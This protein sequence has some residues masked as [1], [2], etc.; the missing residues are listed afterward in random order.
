MTNILYQAVNVPGMQNK[1]CN[2]REEAL[3]TTPAKLELIEDE[4]GLVFN[5]AFNPEIV[6][7]DDSYQNEQGYSAAFRK[8][9]EAVADLCSHHLNNNKSTIVD[10]G[11]GKGMFIEILREQGLTAVG[12][13]NTYQGEKSYIRKSFFGRDC[14]EQGD[15]LTLRHVLEHISRPWQFLGEIIEA[16]KYKGL[17]YIEVPDL[18]WILASKAYFDIFHEHVNYFREC[19]F[20]TRFGSAIVYLSRSFGGQYLSLIIDLQRVNQAGRMTHFC[21]S[22]F[23][24]LKDR[25]NKLAEIENNTY[26]FLANVERLVIWGAASKGVIFASKA[27]K[28]LRDR[29]RY[30]IDINPNKHGQF[31][32]ISA[33][34]VVDPQIGLAELTPS[35][36]VVIMNPNY[37][38]EICGTIPANQPFMVLRK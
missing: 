2:S 1:L 24:S 37:A 36:L 29:I 23:N 5:R 17:L 38:D 32:P 16:N 9:L 6:I 13:D 12:Y 10:I 20:K 3:G 26:A 15:L 4:T 21:G 27:P 34:K 33:V 7:Y 35:D 11:C 25:F 8:H 30:A 22:E 31:M 14:H 19:D 18:D 28:S